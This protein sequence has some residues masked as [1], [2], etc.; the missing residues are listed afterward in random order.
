VFSCVLQPVKSAGADVRIESLR[1][2]AAAHGH[3]P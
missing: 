2:K 3:I 1:K